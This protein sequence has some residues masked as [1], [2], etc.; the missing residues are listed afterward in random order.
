M[1]WKEIKKH[2]EIGWRIL[3]STTE[4][5]ELAQTILEHHERW[6]GEGYPK[7]I[8]GEYDIK[9]SPFFDINML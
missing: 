2:P 3:K 8:K 6:D 1:K 5:L 9:G 4:F 7:G